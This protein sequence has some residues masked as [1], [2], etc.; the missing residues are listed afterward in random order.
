MVG[1]GWRIVE[2]AEIRQNSL[3]GGGGEVKVMKAGSD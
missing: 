1:G 2:E 3:F